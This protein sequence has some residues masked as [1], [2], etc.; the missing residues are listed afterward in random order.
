MHAHG[1]TYSFL[2]T[3]D[4]YAVGMIKGIGLCHLVEVAI[5][6]PR[7]NIYVSIVTEYP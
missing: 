5:V 6:I 4:T 1:N 7:D 2:S 3:R